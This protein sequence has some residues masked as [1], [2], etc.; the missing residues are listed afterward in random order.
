MKK[1]HG[2][3]LSWHVTGQGRY[4]YLGLLRHAIQS[5][6]TAIAV[7]LKRIVKLLTGEGLKGARK[8][9]LAVT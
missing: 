2:F 8:S 5:H 4:R 6:L 7:N 1:H 9:C 3:G